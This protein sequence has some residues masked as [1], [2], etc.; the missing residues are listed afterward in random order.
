MSLFVYGISLMDGFFKHELHMNAFTTLLLAAYL[1]NWET[2]TCILILDEK[3]YPTLTSLMF[4]ETFVND[5]VIIALVNTIGNLKNALKGVRQLSLE[6]Y[7]HMLKELAFV[8]FFSVFIGIVIALTM[9]FIMRRMRYWLHE[10]PYLQ[11]MLILVAGY[12]SFMVSEI[13]HFAGALTIFCS[14]FILSYYGHNNMN[15]KGQTLTKVTVHFLGYL[16]ESFIFAYMGVYVPEYFISHSYQ[17]IWLI[18]I[19]VGSFY[20]R[21]F[22]IYFLYLI[23]SLFKKSIDLYS[24]KSTTMLIFAGMIRGIIHFLY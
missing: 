11:M 23:A 4:G 2:H 7:L 20:I 18:T 10:N 19:I 12:L 24:F 13:A 1:S 16:P 15:E 6:H 17:L 9:C 5:A 21:A 3:E 22:S 8:S 14:G